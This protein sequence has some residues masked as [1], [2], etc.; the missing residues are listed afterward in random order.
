MKDK[1]NLSKE[2]CVFIVKRN[3]VDYI[4][5]SANLEGIGVTYPDT[6]A[7]LD[8]GV[9]NGLTVNEMITINNLKYAWNY[10][11]EHDFSKLDFAVICDLHRF[12]M[13]KLVMNPGMIR[14]VPVNI[15]GT[16]WVPDFPI[17]S[18]IKEELDDIK[19]QMD[20]SKTEIAIEIMLWMMRKQ[21]FLDGNK[22]T[23]MLFANLYMIEHGCGVISIA[24]EDQAKF[25]QYLISYYE[26]GNMNELKTFIYETSIDG[27]AF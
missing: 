8:G 16:K 19:N 10:V 26:S 20:K 24:K 3:I 1:F 17:K 13:D 9:V 21:M 7:I 4:Y 18:Q 25:F 5:K 11:L 23:A 14:Q 27:I 6:Q 2:Q 12:I 15:G 22:R